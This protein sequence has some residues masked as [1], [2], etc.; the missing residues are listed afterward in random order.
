MHLSHLSIGN[1]DDWIQAK[2]IALQL[3]AKFFANLIFQLLTE[4]IYFG[5]KRWVGTMPRHGSSVATYGIEHKWSYYPHREGLST[6]CC[7]NDPTWI[8]T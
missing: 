3:E 8:P 7:K 6:A 1:Y 4:G 5:L 2:K